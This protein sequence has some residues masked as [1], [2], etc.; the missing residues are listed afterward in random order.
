MKLIVLLMFGLMLAFGGL[1]FATSD[2]SWLQLV[3]PTSIIAWGNW[4]LI[5]FTTFVFSG[6][7]ITYWGLVRDE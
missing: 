6:L 1:Y 3:L 2:L 4:N 5:F 7:G